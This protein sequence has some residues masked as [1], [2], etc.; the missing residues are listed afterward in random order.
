MRLGGGPE[1]RGS[2]PMSIWGASQKGFGPEDESGAR[3]G[4][5]GR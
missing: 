3:L 1:L 2:G 5:W 4:G